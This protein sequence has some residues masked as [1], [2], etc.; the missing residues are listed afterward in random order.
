MDS[1]RFPPLAWIDLGTAVGHV[2]A[3]VWRRLD[4]QRLFVTGGTGF[5]GKWLLATLQAAQQQHRFTCETVILSRDP[6]R[7]RDH[8]AW[9]AGGAGVSFVQGDV[10]D[11]EFPAGAFDAVIHAATDVAANLSQTQTFD[12]C[13]SGTRRALEFAT[14]SG[15]RDF[16]LVSSGAVY[17]QQP[18]SM[19]A[20]P[21]TYAGAPD[22]MS[23]RTGYGQGKR[24][25]EWLTA[26]WAQEHPLRAVTARLFA[27]MGP[28]MPL[29]AH[30]A[31]G[32]FMRAA[33]AGE[34]II[35]EGDGTP[36]RTYLH[37]S[38]MAGWL[39]KILL[40]GEHGSAYN[41]G[42]GEVISIADLAH[43]VCSR[44]GSRSFVEIRG[45]AIEGLGANRYVPDVAKARNTLG[46]RQ[47]MS[48]GE[49]I[50]RSAGWYRGESDALGQ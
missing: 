35:I 49:T 47:T 33:L 4:G 46:L 10:V 25:A 45:K 31:A 14:A 32:N 30:F 7:F 21:E 34:P 40:Q 42:G 48:I 15:A 6:G 8:A 5:V 2:D 29:D 1:P 20:I 43:L 27:F 39:W 22:T 17:G 26:A 38:D 19:L 23:V 16:L 9:L 50:E 11:F 44:L 13:V 41:V 12:T 37:P 18:P 28:G 3:E 36:L 24:A